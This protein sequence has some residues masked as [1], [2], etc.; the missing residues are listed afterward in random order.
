LQLTGLSHRDA[1]EG[2]RGELLEAADSD[3]LRDD[4]ESFFLH[5]LIG[6]KVQTMEGEALGEVTE[7]LQPGG[8]DVYVVAGERGEILVPAVGAVIDRIDV[9]ARLIT[10]TPLPG[11]V[12]ETK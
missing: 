7:V 1:V 6:M 4:E 5:E 10:I 8:N 2:Y 11:M 12:D 9:S 3:V